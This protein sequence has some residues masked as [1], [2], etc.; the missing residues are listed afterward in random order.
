MPSPFPTAH[1][2]GLPENEEG[3]ERNGSKGGKFWWKEICLPLMA[4]KLRTRTRG[5]ATSGSAEVGTEPHAEMLGAFRPPPTARH[6]T[7]QAGREGSRDLGSWDSPSST[8]AR[9]Q[10]LISP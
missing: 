9:G 10:A 3:R 8:T 4:P 1:A 6:R 5:F 7:H 2:E